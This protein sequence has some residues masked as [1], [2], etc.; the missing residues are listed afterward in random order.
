MVGRI[1]ALV[2]RT[3]RIWGDRVVCTMRRGR[4]A[5]QLCRIP[6][7]HMAGLGGRP[8]TEWEATIIV[9]AIFSCVSFGAAVIVN[10]R[11]FW[12]Q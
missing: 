5:T 2:L 8:V 4:T 1:S 10:L 11:E 9:G 7:A 3:P 12:R 6:H